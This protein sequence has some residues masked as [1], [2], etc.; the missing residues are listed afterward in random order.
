MASQARCFS[1]RAGKAA[2]ATRFAEEARLAGDALGDVGLVAW[3]A[4]EAETFMS[5]VSG[6][7]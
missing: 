2:K 6:E 3:R 7:R 4:M 1:A 5:K